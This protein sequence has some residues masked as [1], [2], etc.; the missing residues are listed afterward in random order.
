MKK[1]F[2]DRNDASISM[3]NTKAA[4]RDINPE[5]IPDLL[6]EKDQWICWNYEITESSNGFRVTKVPINCNTLDKASTTNP[7][8]WN[9]FEE[10][11]KV[12]LANFDNKGVCGVGYVITS[13]DGIVG[14]DFDNC[15]GEDKAISTEVSAIIDP[16]QCY[17]EASPSMTG[18][19]VFGF[20]KIPDGVLNGGAGS[21]FKISNHPADGLDVEVYQHSRFFT[22]TSMKL[23]SKPK[24]VSD[25]QGLIDSLS[26]SKA[27][28]INSDSNEIPFDSGNTATDEDVIDLNEVAEA[29]S[30]Q[31]PKQRAVST[32]GTHPNQSEIV[33][34]IKSSKQSEI[35]NSLYGGDISSYASHSEADLA[36]NINSMLV[37]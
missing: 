2:D 22:V 17:T 5:N 24:E 6:K 31:Q 15:I 10:C 27:P 1:V 33:E 13:D 37:V 26:A 23:N 35:F 36:P 25:I 12:Y 28:S 19:K 8:T 30:P 4:L 29:L 3:R 11:M 34:K 16:Y 20:G 7:E 32:N 14:I 18:L 9:T 21:G